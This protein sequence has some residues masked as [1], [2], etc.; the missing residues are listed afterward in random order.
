M[1]GVNGTRSVRNVLRFGS[2]IRGEDVPSVP[3]RYRGLNG[4]AGVLMGV[5]LRPATGELWLRLLRRRPGSRLPWRREI[6]TVALNAAQ[7]PAPTPDSVELRE[8][9]H[10]HC[11][12]GYIGRME[13]VTIE[14]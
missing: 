11:H 6:W 13:G 2:K 4:P 14:P 7:S 12:E 1:N 8:G 9:M 10:V 5:R 3:Q